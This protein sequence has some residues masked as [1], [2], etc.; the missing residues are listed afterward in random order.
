MPFVKDSLSLLIEASASDLNYSTNRVMKESTIRSGY[1]S[2]EEAAEKVIYGPEIVPVVQV[3]NEF[4]TEMNF[5]HPFMKT[6]RINSIAEAL[7]IVAEAN[8]LKAGDVGLLIESEKGVDECI[9]KA[10]ESGGTKKKDVVLEKIGK[11]VDLT[12][13]LKKKGIKVK[14]KKADVCPECGKVNCECSKN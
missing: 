8:G 5:L 7:S 4:F 9:G 6:N 2:I 14:K 13:N 11:A 1:E 10:L 12:G 3:G